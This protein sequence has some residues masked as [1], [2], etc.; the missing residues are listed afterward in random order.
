MKEAI[1]LIGGG[2]HCKVCI[3]VIEAEN[4]YRIAGIVDKKEKIGTKVL[5]YEIFATDE[6]A[7]RLTTQY[8]LFLITIGQIKTS[9]KR[10]T[11]FKMW[12]RSGAGFATI[13]S[14]FSY[15]SK[16]ASI[17]EG[18]VIL[19]GVYINSGAQIGKNCIINTSSVIEHDSVVADHCHISMGSVVTGG[20]AIKEGVFIGSNSTVVD[21]LTIAKNTVIGAGSVVVKS[22]N[23][24]GT[25]AGNPARKLTN[26]A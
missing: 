10:R 18:T 23:E 6:D 25:Y 3:D 24:S 20:C 2:G 19:H 8:R 22:I 14:R 26:N 11:L 5:G 9:E 17:G 1:V 4:K 7:P 21:N 15:V 12:K 16:H 13:I